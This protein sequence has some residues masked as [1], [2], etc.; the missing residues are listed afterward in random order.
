MARELF[1]GEILCKLN[2]HDKTGEMTAKEASQFMGSV[3]ADLL[4]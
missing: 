2:F 1:E 4:Y 3:R